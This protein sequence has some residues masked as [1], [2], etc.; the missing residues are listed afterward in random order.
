[1]HSSEKNN[2][3][4]KQTEIYVERD[5]LGQEKP[6][7]DPTKPNTKPNRIFIGLAIVI[8]IAIIYWLCFNF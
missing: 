5:V 2:K 6:H 7:A 8:V 1:M 3:K 4:E